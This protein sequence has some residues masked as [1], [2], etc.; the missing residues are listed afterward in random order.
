M[1]FESDL[2]LT[3]NEPPLKKFKKQLEKLPDIKPEIPPLEAISEL[4]PA[5]LRVQLL[6]DATMISGE[7]KDVVTNNQF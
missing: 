4:S 3:V 7:I 5:S 6:A 2:N 1:N